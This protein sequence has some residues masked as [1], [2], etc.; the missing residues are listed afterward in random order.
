MASSQAA[1]PVPIRNVHVVAHL[2]R[3]L[4]PD[5]TPRFSYRG[6][7][8][9]KG[10]AVSFF[11]RDPGLWPEIDAYEATLKEHQDFR[12]GKTSFLPSLRRSG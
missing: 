11:D 4:N 8:T 1:D 9:I 6:E 2:R 3:V 12:S 5:Q 7:A 10:R